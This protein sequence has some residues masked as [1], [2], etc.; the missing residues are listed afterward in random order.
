MA[1]Q[2]LKHGEVQKIAITR[3]VVDVGNSIGFLPGTMEEKVGP[4]LVPL[5]DELSYYCEQSLLKRLLAEKKLEIVPLSMMRGRTFNDTF[6][7]CDEAQNALMSEL[8]MLL[9]R[10]GAQSKMVLSGDLEQSDLPRPLRGAFETCIDRL[11]DI[12]GIGVCELQAEDIV[13]H[14]LIATIEKRLQGV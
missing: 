14:R 13:R 7:I 6:V 8:R 11:E 9:T 12:E 3:P 5:F 10:I 1:V 2:M 4:Y